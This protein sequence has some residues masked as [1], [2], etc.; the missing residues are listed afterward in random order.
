MQKLS[1]S[2]AGKLGAAKTK[3]LLEAQKLKKIEV[4]LLNPNRCK[5]CDSVIPYDKKST[6]FCNRSCS[7]SYNNK[8]RISKKITWNCLNCDKEY[9]TDKHK[10]GKFCN[11]KCQQDHEFNKRIENWQKTGIIGVGTL[12]KYLAIKYGYKCSICGIS[13]WNN[14][15]ITLELEHKDG[16]SENNLEDNVCLI[17]P[18][19]HSQTETY[20][21]KNKGNGR[22][23]RMIR[24]KEGKSF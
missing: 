8:Q 2:E 3:I 5:N 14:N 24:Y 13:E 1:K 7:A 20:K 10:K 19:C 23:L 11:T 22:H 18:N 4:Y 6:L 21:G 17:C 16:N 15:H 9:V 12:K